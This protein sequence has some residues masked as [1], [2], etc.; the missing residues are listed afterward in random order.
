[1]KRTGTA[2]LPLHHGRCPA[3][4]FRR[5]KK[6]SGEI[7]RVIV[8]EYGQDEF[9]RRIADPFWFQAFGCVLGYDWHSSGLSTTVTGALKE[10]AKPEEIGITI[11][12]GKGR[13]SRKTLEE[14]AEFGDRFSLSTRKID[15]LRYAS[16]MT[17][18]IDSA[19]IQDSYTLYH[20]SFLLTEKGKWA[21]IQQGMNPANRYARRYH[22]LSESVKTLIEEPHNAICC[23]RKEES[24]LNMT[25]ADSREA[26]EISV[27]I[28]RENPL[29]LQNC[30]CRQTLLQDFLGRKTRYMHMPKTH[31]I[32]DMNK[33]DMET[34]KRAYE[35]QP[36][37][38]EE[39]LAIHGIGAKSIRALALISELIYGKPP[40]WK[41]PVKFSFSHGGKDSVP[42][43]V[44][45]ETY[46]KSIE[47]LKTGIEGA[48]IGER[49]RLNAVK[50]LQDYLR[51]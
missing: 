20:H 21:V 35:I 39:L 36:E 40:D 47:I 49:E 46:D 6:L 48:K 50:R 41:D 23:N 7:A 12:G 3:W 29:K 1:M 5:M 37:S 11:C 32:I 42:Y 8:Y 17:A 38:Y 16:R 22:W 28:V 19:C 10:S 4:L 26:R 14:I 43:P 27:D 24:V 30:F 15:R 18:K 25:S 34:L 45:R 2:D 13:A 33:R 31:Y 51:Y 44:D 9:L